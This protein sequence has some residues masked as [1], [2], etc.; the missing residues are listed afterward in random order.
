MEILGEQA[1]GERSL[2]GRDADVP[3]L[4]PEEHVD[5][6]GVGKLGSMEPGDGNPLGHRLSRRTEQGTG[7]RRLGQIEVKPG[8]DVGVRVRFH[9]PATIRSAA[10]IWATL[11]GWENPVRRRPSKSGTAPIAPRTP[12]VARSK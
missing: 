7:G 2:L 8:E 6:D 10:A 1:V 5:L 3:A 9:S 11:N 4:L 12:R